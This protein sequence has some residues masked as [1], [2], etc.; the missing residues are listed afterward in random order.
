MTLKSHVSGWSS[1]STTPTGTS[2]WWTD[3][4]RDNAVKGP[5]AGS[6]RQLV[7]TGSNADRPALERSWVNLE[8][9]HG[10]DNGVHAPN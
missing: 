8:K 5:S 1:R 9:D 3:P 2:I 7:S 10:K 4:Y 6:V